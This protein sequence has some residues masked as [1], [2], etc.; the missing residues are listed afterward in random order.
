MSITALPAR[1]NTGSGTDQ[2][3]VE[4]I[5]GKLAGVVRTS[6]DAGLGKEIAT[7]ATLEE[8][9]V[10]IHHLA[11]VLEF[12]NPDVGGR[13]RVL[14]DANSAMGTVST[15]STVNTVSTVTTMTN[16][17]QIGGLAANQQMIALTLGSEADLRR[18]IVIT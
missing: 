18:N 8:M 3:A 4:T 2:L 11:S 10:A 17:A 13:L 1:A 7:Q 12:L 9:A 6:D 16:Q 15:V 14:T 5:D